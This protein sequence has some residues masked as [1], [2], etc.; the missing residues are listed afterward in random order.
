MV[1]SRRSAS[2]RQSRPKRTLAW[3]P[4]VSTSSRSVVTSN[5]RLSITTVMVPCSMPVG[6]GL[7]PAAVARRITSSR[8]RGGGDVEFVDR[9]AEQRVAHRAA[10]HARLLAVAIEHLRAAA[11]AAP[12]RSHAASFSERARL[13]HRTSSRNELAV[14]DM[15]R[16]VGRARRRAGEMR[17][18]DEAADHQDR[19]R[20]CRAW[21]E[22][23]A[24]RTQ[25]SA[26]PPWSPPDR[27]RRSTNGARNSASSVKTGRIIR[28]RSVRKGCA[29]YPQSRPRC[30]GR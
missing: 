4:K 19:A 7:K 6:T 5:G 12:S 1:K 22:P 2:A 24:A 25:A 20:R 15:G 13:A 17:E 27:W 21:R 11:R 26:A 14:L 9:L 29:G 28:R 10:D 16:L 18:I 30:S 23:S 3:R 8:N